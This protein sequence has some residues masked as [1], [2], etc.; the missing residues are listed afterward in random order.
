MTGKEL[1][2]VSQA[3]HSGQLAGDGKFTES[4]RLWLEQ[5]IGCKKAL[6][7]HSC[8]AALEIAAILLDDRL[9]D[10]V[11]VPSYTFVSTTLIVPI[12]PC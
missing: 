12:V 10:Q 9:D 5:S 8:T 11:I 3:H 7:T 6:M 4:C 2:Y 1:W